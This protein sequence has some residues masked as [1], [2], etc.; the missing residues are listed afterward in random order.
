MQVLF[1]IGL[2][3]RVAQKKPYVNKI[4]R[5]KR[6]AYAKVMM[7][8]PFDYGKH[9]LWSDESKFNLFGYDGKTMV[10]RSTTE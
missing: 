10:W 9:V 4:N 2:N 3:G 5:G 1:E 6:I 7:E 8:K